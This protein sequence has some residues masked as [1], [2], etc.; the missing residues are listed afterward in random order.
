MQ[1]WTGAK[2]LQYDL[3][4]EALRVENVSFI[5]VSKNEL[6]KTSMLILSIHAIL[7]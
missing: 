3:H 5:L 7:A 2:Q 4:Y 6:R 1:L